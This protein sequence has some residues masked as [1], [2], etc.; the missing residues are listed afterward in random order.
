MIRWLLETLE[1]STMNISQIDIRLIFMVENSKVFK[2]HL[3]IFHDEVLNAVKTD[4][5]FEVS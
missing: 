2:R 4:I 1:F 3:I 5:H